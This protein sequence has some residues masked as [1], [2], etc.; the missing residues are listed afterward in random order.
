[1]S[2][3]TALRPFDILKASATSAL[4]S[5]QLA[6]IGNRLVQADALFP[7]AD[8]ASK[9][10]ERKNVKRPGN[11]RGTATADFEWHDQPVINKQCVE[12][13]GLFRH[14]LKHMKN[15]PS[16]PFSMSRPIR[17]TSPRQ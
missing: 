17:S 15:R 4:V 16:M 12:V 5:K 1:M 6:G 9:L 13:F 3:R 11:H 2:S 8:L 14:V 10:G 7:L